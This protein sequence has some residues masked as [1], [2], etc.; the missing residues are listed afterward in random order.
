MNKKLIY[1]ILFIVIVPVIL[2][3]TYHALIRDPSKR[4]TWLREPPVIQKANEEDIFGDNGTKQL[5]ITDTVKKGTDSST[6]KNTSAEGAKPNADTSKKSTKQVTTPVDK[7]TTV[8]NN[9]AEESSNKPLA[10]TYNQVLRLNSDESVLFFDARN[11]HE[12]AE[13][14]IPRA[15]NIYAMDF[16]KHIP[17]ILGLPDKNV[18]IVVFCGGGDCDLSHELSDKLIQFGFKRVFIYLGG[19][20]EWKAKQGK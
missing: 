17:Y 6:I 16:E 18:R 20:T 1:E 12:F 2:G 5:P 7:P 13:G 3:V 8:N 4:L 10:V 15:K 19:Y 11:E 14:T 9:Q